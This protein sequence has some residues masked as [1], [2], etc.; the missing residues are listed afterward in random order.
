MILNDESCLFSLLFDEGAPVTGWQHLVLAFQRFCAEV[1]ARSIA[2]WS[3][4]SGGL[5]AVQS[6][7]GAPGVRLYGYHYK[8]TI[9]WTR[10]PTM[11]E[12]WT[13]FLVCLLVLA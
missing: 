2:D 7:A 13:P 3:H 6:L 10:A 5:H 4:E 12:F 9:R 11:L 8:G 1:R